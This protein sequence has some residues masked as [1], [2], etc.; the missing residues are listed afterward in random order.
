MSGNSEVTTKRLLNLLALLVLSS[1][2]QAKDPTLW[3]NLPHGGFTTIGFKIFQF[4]DADRGNRPIQVS[5]WYPAQGNN[6]CAR[7]RYKDYFLLSVIEKGNA[8]TDD[9][10]NTSLDDYQKQ[11]ASMGIPESAFEQWMQSEMGATPDA[12]SFPGRYPLILIAQGNFQSAHHQAI[13]AEFLAN[14]GYVVATCPSQTRISGPMT[15]ENDILPSAQ[16][17][18]MDLKFILQAL[19]KQLNIDPGKVGVVAHSFGAR[20]ALLLVIQTP[21]VKALVSLDGGIGNKQGKGLIERSPLFDAQKVTVPILHFYEDVEQ[22]MV[23][24]FDLL[25][26]LVHS[27]RYLMKIEK[28]RHLYFTSLGMVS[29][30]IP[31]GAPSSLD[32][33]Q[34]YEA[35]CFYTLH[36]LNAY[37]K[38]NSESRTLLLKEPNQNGLAAEILIERIEPKK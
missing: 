1:S 25:R 36:F 2:I 3:G 32:I 31:G 4:A 8:L 37:L 15:S 22:F 34:R 11:I 21:D 9:E 35:V 18:V 16:E 28:M 27:E 30:V 26:S 10:A 14:N 33:K 29:G 24:D 12:K 17:Q 6:N 19:G 38:S 20:S 23:P 5:L 7:L 13:L